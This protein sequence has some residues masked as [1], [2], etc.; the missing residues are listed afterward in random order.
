MENRPQSKLTPLMQQYWEAKAKH[1]DKVLLFRMGDFF[2]MFHHDAEVAAPIIGIQLTA[3][4]KKAADETKMC[5]VPH[6][7]V[8]N[9]IQKLLA[10]GQKIAICDQL[11]DP[12]Q[13]KGLVKRGIT[14]I[15]TPGSVYDPEA[16]EPQRAHLLAGHDQKGNL[17]FLDISTGQG[18]YY[19]N[20]QP[21]ALKNRLLN[22]PV[23]ELIVEEQES[24]AEDSDRQKER[25]PFAVSLHRS[26]ALISADMIEIIDFDIKKLGFDAQTRPARS[27][28][29]RLLSYAVSQFSEVSAREWLGS[30]SEVR[31]LSRVELMELSPATLRHL[32]IFESMRGDK[33]GTLFFAMDRTRTSGGARL[34]KEWLLFPLLKQDDIERRLESVGIWVEQ[35]DR[36]TR[37]REKLKSVGDL[38]RRLGRVSSPGCGPRDL[39]SLAESIKNGVAALFEVEP[40]FARQIEIIVEE[41]DR[42]LVEEPPLLIRQGG[43]IRSGV[44]AELDEW[45]QIANSSGRLILEL[46]ARERELTGINSLKV[47]YNSVFGYSIEITNTH[48]DKVPKDRYIRKQ[49]LASA[50]R[51]STVELKEIEE[52][53]LSSEEKR[54]RLEEVEFQALRQFVFRNQ[55]TLNRFERKISELD[56]LAS[57]AQL[58]VEHNYSRPRFVSEGIELKASRHPVIEQILSQS[59]VANDIRLAKNGAMLLTGPNMAGKS[60][61]MRQVALTSLMAQAGSFVPA[62]AA[63]LPILD[64]IATRIG[65][66]DSL[67]E[68]LSTF[69]V[70]MKESAE[71]LRSATENT[72]LVMDEIGRGTATYDGMS[73]AQAI[74]EYV[75]NTKKSMTLFATHYFELTSLTETFKN[76]QNA[77]M[78][79][80]ENSGDI[81]FLY[82]LTQG[83][84]ERSYGVHVAR[85]AGL[86]EEVTDRADL[87]LS[88]I[89]NKNQK[90]PQSMGLTGFAQVVMPPKQDVISSAAQKV[91]VRI[92]ELNLNE[93]TP[94]SALAK[95]AE[96]QAVLSSQ[97][98]SLMP[99]V[100]PP[101]K[102]RVSVNVQQSSF[103]EGS[104]LED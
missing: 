65:A 28:F 76:L 104:L 7:S 33:K 51:Y 93:M 87:L 66:S 43:A 3:R 10:A 59:F 2:E 67:S 13:A 54:T 48:K 97:S 17:A 1:P 58:A 36:R 35:F 99:Q 38:A 6:H 81:A 4:N 53:V 34:L 22:H 78:A 86:P 24:V 27:V 42:V 8:A 45:I 69:M 29:Q 94:I 85:L 52:K 44:N 96:L 18:F 75:L 90:L 80:Y 14:R 71:I 72:L 37:V 61:L 15:L 39:R 5:G 9:A 57:L 11:E 47:K 95:L 41:F 30:L 100:P 91:L 84:A 89:E 46:E 26:E 56:C 50:E 101:R 82:Q 40:E 49:T 32:E 19:Q 23:V 21:E 12:A 77:H 55:V 83:P 68:G 64:R 25:F 92:R 70:E 98:A 103:L 79:I 60:T 102:G 20:L 88:Q 73:L 63:Q 74:L 31:D 16:L 62:Q